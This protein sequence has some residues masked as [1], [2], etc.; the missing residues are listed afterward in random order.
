MFHRSWRKAKR[1]EEADALQAAVENAENAVDGMH[2][3]ELKVAVSA[4]LSVIN[5]LE[6][7]PRLVSAQKTIHTYNGVENCRKIGC[8]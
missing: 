5:A 8:D 6:V 2:I 3:Q 4:L 1:K 7:S